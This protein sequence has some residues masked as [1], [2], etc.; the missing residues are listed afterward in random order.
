[1]DFENELTEL[2][3]KHG[4]SDPSMARFVIRSID[5]FRESWNEYH[6]QHRAANDGSSNAQSMGSTA[7]ET[8]N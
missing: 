7:P 4:Y 1:M 6:S 5:N 3:K 2:L 8:G